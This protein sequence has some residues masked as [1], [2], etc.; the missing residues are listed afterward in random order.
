MITLYAADGFS[1]VLT[2][3]REAA[4]L[5]RVFSEVAAELQWDLSAL[6]AGNPEECR[7]FMVLK[8]GQVVAGVSPT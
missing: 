6:L 7:Y 4:P 1:I 3:T 5:L 2:G 8:E